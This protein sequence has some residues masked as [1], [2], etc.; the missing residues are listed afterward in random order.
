M[1]FQISVHLVAYLPFLQCEF[2][3]LTFDTCG[4][5]SVV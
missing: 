4:Y 3:M 1:H 2:Q 5:S